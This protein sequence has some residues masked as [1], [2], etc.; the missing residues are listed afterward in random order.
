VIS[1]RR[2]PDQSF[3]VLP[4]ED[5]PRRA[6]G[7]RL[8]ALRPGTLR[9]ALWADRELRRL[10]DR[11]GRLGM[12]G[13]DVTPPPDVGPEGLRG[14][15]AVLRR[16][17][18]TCLEEALLLQRWLVAHGDPQDVVIGVGRVDGKAAAHAWLERAQAQGQEA[19]EDVLRLPPPVTA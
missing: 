9:A 13:T 15:L 5:E 17:E 10:N 4:A 14:V 19:Y 11:L 2:R 6:L 8:A 12:Q 7:D 18:H 16:R 3:G 1:F